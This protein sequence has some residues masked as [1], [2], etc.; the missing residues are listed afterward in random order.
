MFSIWSFSSFAIAIVATG[1]RRTYTL[2]CNSQSYIHDKCDTIS[3]PL[4]RHIYDWWIFVPSLGSHCPHCFPFHFWL[5]FGALLWYPLMMVSMIACWWHSPGPHGSNSN[6]NRSKMS[7]KRQETEDT[8]M[9]Y[10]LTTYNN[11]QRWRFVW[12]WTHNVSHHTA[13]TPM[14]KVI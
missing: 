3:S 1:G 5:F 13:T 12:P 2:I 14:R 10:C 7:T 8:T 6:S 4:Y 9:S 11:H